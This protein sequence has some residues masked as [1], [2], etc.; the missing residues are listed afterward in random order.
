MTETSTLPLALEASGH[1]FAST[2]VRLL[3]LA[4]ARG[5]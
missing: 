5:S 1:S 2:C 4:A 3:E